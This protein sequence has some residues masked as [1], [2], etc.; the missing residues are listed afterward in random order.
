[1]G[2]IQARTRAMDSGMVKAAQLMMCRQG[3]IS[4]MCKRHD[5]FLPL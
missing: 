3:N 4:T 5:A 2:D 1:M